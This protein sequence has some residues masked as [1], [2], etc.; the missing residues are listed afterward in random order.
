MMAA[1]TELA[2]LPRC[3]RRSQIVATPLGPAATLRAAAT[4]INSYVAILGG[5]IF[6]SISAS[7]KRRLPILPT[8]TER[9]RKRNSPLFS[10]WCKYSNLNARH[11]THGLGVGET[12]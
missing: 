6:V 4:T 11:Q 7:K 9:L 12:L 2:A 5:L 8:D 10:Y 3:A 1:P